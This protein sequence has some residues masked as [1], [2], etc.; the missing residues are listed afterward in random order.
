MGL[1]IHSLEVLS[2]DVRRA[3]Y[4]YILD[5]GWSEPLVDILS[6]NFQNLARWSSNNESAIITGVGEIGH[7][8][9]EVL[10]WHKINGQ[11][12]SEILPAILIT[13]T[14][15]HIFRLYLVDQSKK[16]EHDLRY[17][18]IPIKKFCKTESEVMRLITKI[19]TDVE[20]KRDLSEFKILKEL[21]PGIGKAIVKSIL[22]EPNIQGIGFSFNKLSEYLK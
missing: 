3:Y 7:F 17:I 18:L 8:D 20:M 5:Y 4:I 1:M 13:R 11:E 16:I 9:T 12:A 19:T 10:S 6:R 15:P 22:L 2:S 14:N 21:K